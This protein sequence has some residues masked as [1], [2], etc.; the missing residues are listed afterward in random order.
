VNRHSCCCHLVQLV[1]L[2]W[3]NLAVA[4]VLEQNLRIADDQRVRDIQGV[5]I[6]LAVDMISEPLYL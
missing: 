3:Y 1:K 4:H 6:Y 2:H 5:T